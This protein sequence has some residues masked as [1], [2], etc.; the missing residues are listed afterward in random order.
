MLAYVMLALGRVSCGGGDA[1]Q[2]GG[3]TATLTSRLSRVA[4]DVKL[5]LSLAG[6]ACVLLSIGGAVGLFG[7]A[8]VRTT[9]IIF[10]I[11]PF[12]VSIGNIDH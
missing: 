6:T 8:E 2:A 11:L 10:Q 4:T 1:S 9:L 5:S 3:E 7:F 12:L